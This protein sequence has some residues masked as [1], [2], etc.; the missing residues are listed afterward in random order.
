MLEE[1]AQKRQ[2]QKKTGGTKEQHLVVRVVC[3]YLYRYLYIHIY[4]YTYI[5]THTY[6]HIYIYI[7]Y[8]YIPRNPRPNKVAGLWDDLWSKDSRSYLHPQSLVDL[9]FLGAFFRFDCPILSDEF[10][11]MMGPKGAK[12]GTPFV[13]QSV[14]F[15]PLHSVIH[16]NLRYPPPRPPPPI[17]KALLRDY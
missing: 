8:C 7:M 5:Y 10:V 17:N 12:K 1:Q 14:F 9:D 15:I 3:I 2:Q 11:S 6:A 4:I 13:H 16:G